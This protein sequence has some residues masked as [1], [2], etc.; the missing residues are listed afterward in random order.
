[1][2]GKDDQSEFEHILE[3]D[4]FANDFD[5]GDAFLYPERRISELHP[6]M[7]L[8]VIDMAADLKGQFLRG[9]TAA[10]WYVYETTRSPERQRHFFSTGASRHNGWESPHQYGLAVDMA[11]IDAQG[12]PIEEPTAE[13]YAELHN[14]AKRHGLTAPDAKNPGHLEHPEWPRL[15]RV[16]FWPHQAR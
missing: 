1:M 12:E 10:L 9:E 11:A 14:A 7:I 2:S 6:M 3:E 5:D 8:R 4:E 16:C 15:W 13:Q